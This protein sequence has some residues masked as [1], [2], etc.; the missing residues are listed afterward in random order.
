MRRSLKFALALIIGIYLFGISAA[1]GP[2]FG[3]QELDEKDLVA[4]VRAIVTGK[5]IRIESRWDANRN[6]IYTDIT[7]AL[8]QVLKGDI[9]T[10]EIVIEQVGG[11]LVD[12]Q[13]WLVGSPQFELGENVLLYL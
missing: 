12:R 3:A 4:S 2:A 9:K 13:S 8:S 6:N 11:R 10:K 7:V 5:V 1:R